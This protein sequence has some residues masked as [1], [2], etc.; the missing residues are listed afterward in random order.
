MVP[1]QIPG[2]AVH[3][4]I[5]SLQEIKRPAM[6]GLF[7]IQDFFNDGMLFIKIKATGFSKSE[8]AWLR[9][10]ETGAT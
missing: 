1:A 10:K 4:I 6:A 9:H 5:Q 3:A 2:A 7:C 8:Q